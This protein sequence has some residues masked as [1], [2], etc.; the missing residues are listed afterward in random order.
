MHIIKQSD[1]NWEDA[2][3]DGV[4]RAILRKSSSD[5]RTNLIKL[6]AGSKAPEHIH[7]A[8]EDVYIISGKV[9]VNGI[10]LSAGDYLYTDKGETHDLLAVED[11]LIYVSSE[12]PIEFIK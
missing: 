9:I 1:L 8:E 5:G 6:K 4:Q 2:G 10:S 12:L 7:K 11:S 3:Y